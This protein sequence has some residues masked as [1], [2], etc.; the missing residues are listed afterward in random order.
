MYSKRG[1]S[2]AQ[3]AWGIKPRA[4]LEN[5]RAEEAQ[6]TAECTYKLHHSL[7]DFFHL[8]RLVSSTLNFLKWWKIV[9]IAQSFVIIIDA[10]TKLNH[11]MNASRKLCGLVQVEARREQ[12]SIE[13]Q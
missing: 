9:V 2:F 7:V 3:E 11:S 8:G 1:T 12:G 4:Q 6:D 13:Q 5:V 10:Q